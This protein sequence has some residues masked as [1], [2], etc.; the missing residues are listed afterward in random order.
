MT[1]NPHPEHT[2]STPCFTPSCLVCTQQPP[3][4]STLAKDKTRWWQASTTYECKGEDNLFTSQ[5]TGNTS[6][7]DCKSNGQIWLIARGKDVLTRIYLSKLPILKAKE[8]THRSASKQCR[9]HVPE[10]KSP[11]TAKKDDTFKYSSL[12]VESRPQVSSW[13]LH[14]KHLWADFL[15]HW[16]GSRLIF[17]FIFFR[18]TGNT[19]KINEENEKFS[20]V[21]QCKLI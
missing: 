21:W 12:M 6:N 10:L 18:V 4:C 11:T 16:E 19:Q 3:L 5:N 17:I 13:K 15:C 20:W 14:T 7:N 9:K 2:K 8:G 1:N